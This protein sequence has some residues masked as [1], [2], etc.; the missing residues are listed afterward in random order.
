[1]FLPLL[2][3][4]FIVCDDRFSRQNLTNHFVALFF[5]T[6]SNYF[7]NPSSAYL[8]KG[9]NDSWDRI[10]DWNAP[11]PM[12][13]QRSG[14]T[15]KFEARWPSGDLTSKV[16]VKVVAARKHHTAIRRFRSFHTCLLS[17]HVYRVLYVVKL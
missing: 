4:F 8:N 12:V 15:E 1:M 5:F 2:S 13:V 10:V 14:K 7:E 11:L 17:A 6:Q 16:T 9:I 3:V